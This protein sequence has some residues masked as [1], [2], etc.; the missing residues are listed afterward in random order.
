MC[1]ITNIFTLG[2]ILASVFKQ[3]F[4]LRLSEKES[5]FFNEV[6]KHL[7]LAECDTIVVSSLPF[8]GEM[9]IYFLQF[10]AHVRE[11]QLPR[12]WTAGKKLYLL[13]HFDPA[14]Q[15]LE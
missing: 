14:V 4:F 12:D 1:R 5:T 3:G 11:T 13:H 8:L 15:L 9:F 7:P 2:L 10:E 6:S